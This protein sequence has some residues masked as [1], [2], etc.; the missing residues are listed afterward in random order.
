VKL[1]QTQPLSKDFYVDLDKYSDIDGIG[2]FVRLMQRR[3]Y[4]FDKKVK[5]EYVHFGDKMPHPDSDHARA[6]R[7]KIS[8]T[9][10]EFSALIP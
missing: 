3:L 2:V 4:W 1:N 6:I 5:E 10:S 9:V 7:A 8:R